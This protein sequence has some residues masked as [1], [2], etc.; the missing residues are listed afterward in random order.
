MLRRNLLT[1]VAL[2]VEQQERIT[3]DSE[4]RDT[5]MRNWD[6]LLFSEERMSSRWTRWKNKLRV[7]RILETSVQFLGAFL[8][9][10]I[11]CNKL[12]NYFSITVHCVKRSTTAFF[13]TKKLN[14]SQ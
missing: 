14:F 12:V 4:D 7:S 3:T 2:I 11:F 10:K 5:L 13:R 8:N 9:N 6:K 1:S